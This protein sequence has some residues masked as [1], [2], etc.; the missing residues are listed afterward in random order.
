MGISPPYKF[1]HIIRMHFLCV[2]LF[3]HSCMHTHTSI[4]NY[5]YV[6][7]GSRFWFTVSLHVYSSLCRYAVAVGTQNKRACSCL[8]LGSFQLLLLTFC[9]SCCQLVLLLS[10]AC[11]FSFTVQRPLLLLCRSAFSR[12]I[13]R[14]P[15]PYRT[16]P[17]SVTYSFGY[18]P[19]TPP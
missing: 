1:K 15:F 6:C 19:L 4:Y 14:L 13:Y 18:G 2:T 3:T 5:I 10:T 17:N 12:I 16:L 8:S 9:C 7:S 11:S